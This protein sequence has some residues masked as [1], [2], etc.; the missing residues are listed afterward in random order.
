M[1]NN[2]LISFFVYPSFLFFQLVSMQ[3]E[4][5]KQMNVMVSVPVTKE[6]KRLEGSLGRNLEKVVKANNDALWARLQEENAKQEKLERDR[7][8]QVTNLISNYVN[9]DLPAQLEKILKKEVSSIGPTVARSISQIIEKT[10]STTITESFQVR[11]ISVFVSFLFIQS[12]VMV[13]YVLLLDSLS[14]IVNG[15]VENSRLSCR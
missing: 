13:I 12:I 11:L 8:Q 14:P 4:M 5:Q 6:G 10:I 7:I 9:K 3:K 1:S 15:A 2:G